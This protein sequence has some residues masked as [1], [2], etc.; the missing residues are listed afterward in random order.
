MRTFLRLGESRRRLAVAA[1]V[2]GVAVGLGF[3]A[4]ALADPGGAGTQTITLHN[5]NVVVVDNPSGHDPCNPSDTG[6]LVA[7]SSNEVIHATQQADGTFWFT[8]T[9]EG[10][11]TFTADNPANASASGHFTLWFGE[12]SNN[13]NDVQH[14][15]GTFNLRG[16]DGSHIVVHMIDHIST[17]AHGVPTA[18]FSVKNVTCG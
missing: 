9:D 12:S 4:S 10:T 13:K 2:V 11:A 1:A 15:T 17:N 14:D 16:T 6:H 7:V 5:H 8:E 18:T 3:A